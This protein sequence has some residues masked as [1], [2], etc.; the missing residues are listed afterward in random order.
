MEEAPC[1]ATG[2][3]VKKN[4]GGACWSVGLTMKAGLACASPASDR[5]VPSTLER[6]VIYRQFPLSIRTKNGR[7]AQP[8][9]GH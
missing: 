3:K 6:M 5:S 1:H 4:S 9:G 7:S 8:F 2:K